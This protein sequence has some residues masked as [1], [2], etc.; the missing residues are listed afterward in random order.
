MLAEAE[1]T[2]YLDPKWT[3]KYSDSYLDDHQEGN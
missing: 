2:D 1:H 3:E